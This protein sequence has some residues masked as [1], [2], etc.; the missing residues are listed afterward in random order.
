M[1]KT[2]DEKVL[3]KEAAYWDAMKQLA[4]QNPGTVCR[5]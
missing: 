5:K 3:V 1:K 4:K 2:V